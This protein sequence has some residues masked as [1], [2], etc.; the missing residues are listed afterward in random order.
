MAV[1]L[2]NGAPVVELEQKN[3]DSTRSAPRI[4][5]TKPLPADWDGNV[6]LKIVARGGLYD[7]YYAL[8]PDA[9][10]ALAEGADGTMLST[11]V[12]RG[13]VGVMFGV[14]AYAPKGP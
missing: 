9:W 14:Y 7:F 5:A 13:F 10:M 12:A 2:V 6:F 3:G 1:T 4:V 8:K 11:K